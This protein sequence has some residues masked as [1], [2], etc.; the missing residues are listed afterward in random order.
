M[1]LTQNTKGAPLNS[2][3]ICNDP[4]EHCLNVLAP[5][6]SLSFDGEST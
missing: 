4:A 2:C 3:A 5:P 6:P 1:N